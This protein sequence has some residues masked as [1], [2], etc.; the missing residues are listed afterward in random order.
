[1]AMRPYRQSLKHLLSVDWDYFS[2]SAELVFDSPFWG[3]RDTEF[4]RFEAWEARALKRGGSGFEVLR[5]DFPLFG[6]PFELLKF[7]GLPCYATVSHSDAYAL[8]ERLGISSVVNLD[9][10]HDLYSLSG[11]PTRVRPG[12]WAGLA[13]EHGLISSYNCIYPAWHETVRVTEGFDLSRTELE[14]P[15]RFRRGWSQTIPYTIPSLQRGMPKFEPADFGALLLVQSPAWT[16]PLY[17]HVFLELCDGLNAQLISP[18]LERPFKHDI[19][20][21]M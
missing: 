10:H 2:G 3:S 6:N 18:I 19:K 21:P 5:D 8:I 12:N 4:D 7:A 15:E 14:L 11:D 9:S 13:L 1:M 20:T 17:D 16:N